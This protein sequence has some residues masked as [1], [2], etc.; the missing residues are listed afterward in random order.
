MGKNDRLD[1]T[2]NAMLRVVSAAGGG[3]PETPID[4]G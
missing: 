3:A 4:R 2:Y 1:D